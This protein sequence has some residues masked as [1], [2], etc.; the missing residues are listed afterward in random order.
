[1]KGEGGDPGRP[2]FDGGAPS[3]GEEDART[4]RRRE[5]HGTAGMREGVEGEGLV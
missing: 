5:G 1:M 3:V 2:S 4:T